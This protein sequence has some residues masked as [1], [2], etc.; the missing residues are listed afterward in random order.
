MS[1]TLDAIVTRL[2]ILLKC[3]EI[4]QEMAAIIIVM[5]IWV[6]TFGVPSMILGKEISTLCPQLY[7]LATKIA[8]AIGILVIVL[9]VLQML[10][11][12]TVI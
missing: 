9:V 6:T 11:T 3:L 1:V 8:M 4:T 10:F 5:L 12:L 2:L 7:T